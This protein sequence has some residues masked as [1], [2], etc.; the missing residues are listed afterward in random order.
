MLERYVKRILEARVYDVAV[1]TPLE[2]APQ[3]S[4][5][6]QNRVLIKREDLQPIYSFK[7][8]GAY[9]KIARLDE[10]QRQRGVVA[11]SAGNHAQGVALSA[12][13]LGI[14]AHIVM[15]RNTPPIKINGVRSRGGHVILHG[16]NYDEAS[17]HAAELAQAKGYTW[18]PP[19]DDVDVIAGQG[20]VAVEL[21][22]QHGSSLDAVF[23]PVGGGGLIAGMA[24]YIKYLR[25]EVKVIGVE[26]EGSHS[27]AAALAAGRR[28]RLPQD[29]L[30]LFA[31][32]VSVAQVGK[33]PFA[34][35][36]HY[37]D[38]TVTVNTDQICAAIR[39]LFE[40]TRSLAEPAG[41]LAVAG[42]KAW[43]ESSGARDQTLVAVHSGANL[44]FD[45]MRHIAERADVGE[46]REAV[47]AVTIDEAPGSFRRF[48]RVI[49]KR[50]V[51]EFN[52]RYADAS[53]AHVF[54]GLA[55]ANPQDRAG[56]VSRFEQEGYPV[57]DMTD[58]ELAKVH[59]RHLV[60]GRSGSD[61]PEL[62]FRFE[63]PER[64][65][66]L[67]NFLAVLGERWNISLFHYRN[68]GAAWGRVLIAFHARRSERRQLLELLQA[69]GYRF[70]EE[71][72]N[73]AYRQF[74]A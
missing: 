43:V 4:S 35:A 17:A 30:D 40:D 68:H 5:R 70:W 32:G 7:I 74:L 58:N 3:L 50:S 63:F 57:V 11:A 38:E 39:D 49:G 42:L 62:V 21:L 2:A 61:H 28:V 52:Y 71:T 16:D 59:A 55:L 46:R 8:R 15:G 26:P 54:V 9:N 29:K 56:L 12:T 51:T 27:L 65:G 18:V 72:D 36:R 34:I 66:A 19:Y 13:R 48:C 20:T 67:M 25:P 1:E 31:D 33:E 69:T 60:G 41:A 64:P 14:K 24:A 47:L 53:R 73:P 6:L 44:N 37:V 45:R 23:V 22:R 10:A